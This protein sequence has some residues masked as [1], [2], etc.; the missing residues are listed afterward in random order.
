MDQ[1][2][3]KHGPNMDHNGPTFDLKNGPKLD[4]NLINMDQK[5]TIFFKMDHKWTK[6]D[7][8]NNNNK[9]LTKMDQTWANH[10]Q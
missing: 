1:T 6:L 7:Q 10:G 2:C 3:T 9:K 5:W 8:Q 4:K